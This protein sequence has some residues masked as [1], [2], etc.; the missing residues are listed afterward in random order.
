MWSENG[1]GAKIRVVQ[2]P[3]DEEEA[4]FVISEIQ[5]LQLSEGCSWKDF[6]VIFRM[7]AQS[8]LLEANLRRLQIPYRIVGSRSFFERREVKDLLAYLACI[9]NP[10]DDISLLRIINTPP[11]GI[12]RSTIE[13]AIQFNSI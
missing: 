11:R 10:Q 9:A 12:G 1:E 5:K 7:N 8:R 4:N 6:A 13:L 3:D 2:V